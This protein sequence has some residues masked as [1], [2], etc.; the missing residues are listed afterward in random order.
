[1]A[2]SRAGKS[3]ARRQASARKPPDLR[4]ARPRDLDEVRRMLREYADAIGIDLSFQDFEHELDGL[5]GDYAAPGGGLWLAF[6]GAA[7]AGC[8]AMRKIDRTTCE[9]KRLYVRPA[10]R[11]IG[12]G[13][14]L[15]LHVIKEA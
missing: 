12:L 4:A 15:A 8:V 11:G 5:P 10:V 2:K 1:M 7:P 9:M 6:A 3:A 13:R 14:K